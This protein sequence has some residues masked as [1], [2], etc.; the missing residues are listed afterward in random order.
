MIF[1][2]VD[3]FRAARNIV[4]AATDFLMLPDIDLSFHDKAEL[5]SYRRIL[6]EILTSINDSNVSL[7]E[8]PTNPHLSM[9]LGLTVEDVIAKAGVTNITGSLADK[10]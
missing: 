3:E 9:K 7:T 4:L 5:I 1:N 10:V 2:T 8:F 6:R